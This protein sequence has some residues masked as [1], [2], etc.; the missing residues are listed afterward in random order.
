MA[1]I[2]TQ[3]EFITKCRQGIPVLMFHKIGKCPASAN[4]PRGYVSPAHFDK[5]LDEFKRRNAQTISMSDAVQA[6]TRI[7]NRF[8]ISFDDGFEGTLLHAAQMLKEHGFTAIQFLPAD[9][10]GQ[11]NGWDL[12]VD[13]T[14]ERIMDRSQ[15]QEWLSLGFE[16]GAHTLT[17]P[18]LSAIP[19]AEAKNEI[20][21]S[22]KKLED[23]FGVDVKHFAY[24]Y[25]DYNDA[26]V[27]L[28]RE[29][30]FETA[31]TI[32]PGV[33]CQGVDP[34]RLTRFATDERSFRSLSNY[35]L[36]YLPDDLKNGARRGQRAA[37]GLLGRAY[38]YAISR[39][40][41][42]LNS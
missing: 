31:C 39:K 17:H 33:V 38:R 19:I 10:L 18:H 37:R 13:T 16:I 3:W 27:E 26:V 15:V 2:R 6:K 30:G 5:L 11:L 41:P 32:E 12:G 23:L 34:F 42:T 35:K 40:R 8:V 7:G 28:V 20:V 9:W 14:L 1:A 29:A 22:K 36:S 21:G 25:G 24:P 4:M